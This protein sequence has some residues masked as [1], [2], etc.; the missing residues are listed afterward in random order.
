MRLHLFANLHS[1]VNVYLNILDRGC[2]DIT[3]LWRLANKWRRYCGGSEDGVNY[4]NTKF[5]N[6]TINL[7]SS[8]IQS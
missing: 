4:I 6:N 2:S 8:S 3:R 1:R 5:G 7:F